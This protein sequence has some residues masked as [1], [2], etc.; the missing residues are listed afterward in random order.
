MQVVNEVGVCSVVI[1]S[2][3]GEDWP[4]SQEKGFS[5]LK[6]AITG[7][8]AREEYGF[9]RLSVASIRVTPAEKKAKSFFDKL[10]LDHCTEGDFSLYIHGARDFQ[11]LVNST[12][13]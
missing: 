6:T 2:H 5:E 1:I 13:K 9:G 11:D 8:N 12:Q 10:Q 3:F 7:F 4:E